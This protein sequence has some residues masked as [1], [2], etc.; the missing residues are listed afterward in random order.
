MLFQHGT[1]GLDFDRAREL[2]L[3]AVELRPTDSEARWLAA[4]ALDRGRTAA[5]LPQKYGTQYR[6]VGKRWELHP[7]EPETSDE[8]RRQWSV[9]SLSEALRMAERMNE[10]ARSLER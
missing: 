4:A 9:P 5:G 8:E 3:R 2:A 10:G 1:L 7:V 6:K